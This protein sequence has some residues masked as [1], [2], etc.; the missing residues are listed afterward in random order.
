M[1]DC[2]TENKMGSSPDLDSNSRCICP[3]KRKEHD[4]VAEHDVKFSKSS[5]IDSPMLSFM[6]KWTEAPLTTEN[7][8]NETLKEQVIKSSWLIEEAKTQ[9]KLWIK[10]SNVF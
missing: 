4:D 6:K 3:R 10:V 9:K 8:M 2:P 7:L 5:P 1:K